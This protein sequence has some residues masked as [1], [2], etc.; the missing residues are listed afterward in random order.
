MTNGIL[1]LI[2]LQCFQLIE[3]TQIMPCGKVVSKS[4]GPLKNVDT[5]ISNQ[6]QLHYG[7][8]DDNDLGRNNRVAND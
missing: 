5:K 3:V 4:T 6:N 1:N 8:D 2:N 7:N